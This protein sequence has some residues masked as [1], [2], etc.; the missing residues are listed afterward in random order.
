GAGTAAPSVVAPANPTVTVAGAATAEPTVVAPANPTAAVA[1]ATPVFTKP[2]DIT[3]P[4][5]PVSSIGQTIALGT[6]GGESSREEVTLLPDVKTISWAGGNTQVRV[7]QFAAY[8]DGKLV[9]VA[10]DYFAQADD[11]D[12]YYFGEDVANYEDGQIADHGGS[13]LAGKSGAPPALIMP[14]K[15]QVGMVF[16]PENL[17]GVVYETDEVL[18]LSEKGMTPAGPISDG[19]LIK[20]TLMDGSIEYKVWAAGFGIVEDRSDDGKINLVLLNRANAAPQVVPDSLQT[21]EAQAEDIIDIVPGGNWAKA[22]GDVAAVAEAWKAY[23]GQAATDGAPQAFQDALAS[24][25]DRLQ[26]ASSAKK[27][28]STMQAANDLSA[29]VIDLFSVYHPAVPADLGRLDVFERQVVFDV[30]AGDFTADAD[31]LAKVDAIW[32]RLKPSI[33][34]HNGTDVAKQFDAS[35]TAQRAALKGKDG[36]ALA[37]EANKGLE[38]VDALEKLY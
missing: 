5:F 18:S 30:A 16:N 3:N 34:E 15:P 9:E 8:G 10:Y 36:V 29:A 12:V 31:G 6:E 28:T 2:T 25:L 35:L 19:L 11:G 33:L 23:Q 27:A 13:W 20:E 24:A 26:Q 17:P 14:A 7:T 38:I 1:G 4:Y 37:A 32:A 22:N 21:I